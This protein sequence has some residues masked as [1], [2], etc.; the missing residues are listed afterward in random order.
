MLPESG[1]L[2]IY[3]LVAS[4]YP[5]GGCWLGSPSLSTT[6]NVFLNLHFSCLVNYRPSLIPSH[7]LVDP[8]VL[9]LLVI[10][11]ACSR[12]SLVI[13]FNSI[14]TLAASLNVTIPNT[15]F[16]D[17]EFMIVLTECLTKSNL[18]NPS[19]STAPPWVASVSIEP[20]MSSTHMIET[21]GLAAGA[22]GVVIDKFM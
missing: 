4:N 11:D 10:L 15:S 22:Y 14:S 6:T 7:K 12:F 16:S 19:D 13:S 9:I 18:E 17:K 8:Y 5:L 2:W 1:W 3:S 20:E 21:D